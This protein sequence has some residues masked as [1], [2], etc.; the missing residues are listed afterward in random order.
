MKVLFPPA[1]ILLI[2]LG[3]TTF[4]S[5]DTQPIHSRIPAANE[6]FL[7]AHQYLS[8][9]DPRVGGKMVNARK[10][11]Q[12]YQLA[13]EQDPNFALAY[14]E[15]SRAWLR[16]GYSNPDGA[17][18]DE[19]M[20]AAK[21]ALAKAV[22]LDPNLSDAHLMLAA[23]AF[24]I[25]Y[26]W[27]KADREY[28]QGIALQPNNADAHANYAAYLSAM[29]RFS[30]ALNQATQANTLAPSAATDF[31]FAR[32]Y[33][34]MHR[35]AEAADFCKKSLASQN[36]LAVRFYLGLIYAAEKQ[37]DRAI[38]E[39][40]STTRE[41]NGGALAGLAYAYAMAG[42]R[43]QAQ[44]LLN[45]L[46]AGKESGLIVPYRIAA[47]YLALGNHDKAFE[48]LGKSYAEHDNWTAQLNVDPVMDPLRSDPRFEELLRKMGFRQLRRVGRAG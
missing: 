16:L 8:Q 47:V 28:K 39:L 14:V 44:E 15:M 38:P 11:I 35:Y 5:A 32:I 21:A 34:A 6:L 43:S 33:Y 19:I 40:K 29:G 1:C 17:S 31:V 4:S 30:E 18:N 45:K 27:A 25:D 10:A 24:N 23:L 12:L 3:V 36:N 20:P 26:E 9:S 2:S 22:A 46:Y 42:D 7:Q 37:Y 13:V 48:W 41:N